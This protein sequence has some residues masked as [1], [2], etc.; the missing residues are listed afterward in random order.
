[1]RT[2]ICLVVTAMVWLAVTAAPRA[3]DTP[4][5]LLRAT[6]NPMFSDAGD[7][8]E[9]ISVRHTDGI[10]VVSNQTD[11]SV[12]VIDLSDP[13]HPELLLIVPIDIPT[14][15]P[16]SVAVHPQHDY[17]LVAVGTA[18]VVGT[19][20]AYRLSDGA[21]LDTVAVGVQP[22]AVAISR[23]GQYAVVANE[24]EGIATPPQNGGPGSLS[25]VDLTGFNGV[26]GQ[27]A[28]TNLPLAS[29]A[30]M[31]G[32][33]GGRTDDLARLTIDN[34]PAT[35]EPENIAF[36]HDS[37]FAYVTLQENNAVIR[38]EVRTGEMN[39][40]GVGQTT[41]L[42]DLTNGGGY[43]PTQMLTAFREP[44]GIAVDR[45]GR[46]FITADE[47]DT[48]DASGTAGVRGGRTVSVFDAETG[49]FIA[50]TGNQLDAAAAAAGV[51]PD[52][53][54]NRGGS[55][56]EGV[57]LIDYRGL[58][59]AAVALERA[60]AVALIDLS[61]PAAPT[62]IDIVPTAV[63]PET[64]K[65]FRRGSRLFVASANEVSET[66]SILEVVF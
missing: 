54:S 23:N 45:N 41:H 37:R 22:D 62:V 52:G 26:N 59:L 24:A 33:S 16:N 48:R 2:R 38:L 8:A 64:V 63:G 34:S 15:V 31:P 46:F 55:E 58:T 56:P 32:I 42:A 49:A 13:L 28:V 43:S 18:G 7:N 39:V 66:V 47:G 3:A 12:H 27:L 61:N 5:L 60:N 14:G 25:I 20:A 51:Y 19:V 10:A 21:L 4:R 6:Y 44:D 50:D 57:D 9:V 36:S 29:I 53:R 17:F 30:G 11:L 40:V 65:F 1:M 35:I